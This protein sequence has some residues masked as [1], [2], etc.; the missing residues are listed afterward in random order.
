MCPDM[1]D[2]ILTKYSTRFYEKTH[3]WYRPLEH[4]KRKLDN[5]I[6]MNVNVA[7]GGSVMKRRVTVFSDLPWREK[8]DFSSLPFQYK[9]LTNRST[10][11]NCR[12]DVANTWFAPLATVLLSHETAD[13]GQ[14]LTFSGSIVQNS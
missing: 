7:E 5:G 6:G 9:Q 10:K 14:F 3:S 8:S 2:I 12:I 4:A 11:Q 13:T 1:N